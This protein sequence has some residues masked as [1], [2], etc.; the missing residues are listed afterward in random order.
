MIIY[1]AFLG[2]LL[3]VMCSLER[4][5]SSKLLTLASPGLSKKMNMKP[6]L[7]QGSLLSGLRQRL[8]IIPGRYKA[9]IQSLLCG[10][11]HRLRIIPGRYKATKSIVWTTLLSWL[12]IIPGRYK[13]KKVPYQVDCARGC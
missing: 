7:E 5:I 13:A 11:R 12:L 10:L 6:E 4:I 9:T 2:I 3:H 8:L 1:C